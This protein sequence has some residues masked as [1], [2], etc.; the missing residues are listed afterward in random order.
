MGLVVFSFNN[1]GSAAVLSVARIIISKGPNSGPNSAAGNAFDF[2]KHAVD[3][4][5]HANHV[6]SG[7]KTHL[8]NACANKLGVS[9]SEQ[10]HARLYPKVRQ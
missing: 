8:E 6:I 9:K 3:R 2:S 10:K 5:C 4:K 1:K 7:L